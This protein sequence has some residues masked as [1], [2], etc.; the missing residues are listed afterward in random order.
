MSRFKNKT[1]I[2][3]QSSTTS[4]KVVKSALMSSYT[5]FQCFKQAD[6]SNSGSAI[7]VF[8]KFS[9]SVF[10]FQ[11]KTP[12]NRCKMLIERSYNQHKYHYSSKFSIKNNEKNNNGKVLSY[13]QA[14]L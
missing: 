10:M 2:N 7:Y 1:S 6:Y 11:Y 12:K 5:F 9:L 8:C 13:P 14:K 4:W 3:C